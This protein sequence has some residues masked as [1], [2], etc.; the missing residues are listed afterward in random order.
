MDNH[1]PMHSIKVYISALL[2]AG[3]CMVAF[4][5][6]EGQVPTE[7]QGTV[8]DA[9]TLLP[10]NGISVSVPEFSSAITDSLGQFTIQVPHDESALIIFGLGYQSREVPLKGRREVSVLLNEQGFHSQDELAQLYYVTKPM[11]YTTQSVVT[12]DVSGDT[13]KRPGSSAEKVINKEVAGLGIMARSGIPGIGSNMFIRGFSS[14]YAGNQPLIILDGFIYETAQYGT[15]IIKG[16]LTNPLSSINTNDIENITVVRDA[17][18]IYGSRASNGVIYI[19][20]IHPSEMATKIDF[21]MYGGINYAPEQLPLL[22][23]EDYRAYLAEILQTSGI[24]ADSLRSMPFMIDDPAYSQYYGYHNQTN[25]QDE[26]F[27]NSTSQNVNLKITGGDD[28]ALYALSVGYQKH[29]GI[30]RET[31]YSRYSFRFNSHIRISSKLLLKTNLGF[32][33]NQHMLKEDGDAPHTNPLHTS[34]IKAPFL[35][36]NVLSSTGAVSPNLADSDLFGV[37]NPAAI[38]QS[39]SASSNNYKILGSVDVGYLFSDH[40]RADNYLGI[41][42]DKTRDNIFVPYLGIAADTLEEGIAGN[43]VAHK[44]DRYF[45]IYNDFRLNY[46]RTLAWKHHINALAGARISVNK[47]Q[48]DWGMDYNTPND[49]IRSLGSGVSSM[50]EVDGYFG[51]WNWVTYYAQAEYDYSHK[52]LV[53][54]NLALDGS[55]RFGGEADGLSLFG[56]KF[57]VFPSIAAAWI[58]SSEPFMANAAPLDFLKLRIS[59]GI[60]GND[61]IGNHTSSKYYISQNLL[62]SEGLVKGNLYNPGLQW[63]TNKKLNGGIDLAVF[64]ERFSLSA[65]LYQNRSMNLINVIDASPLSGFE[66][67]IDN[68][69]SFTCSGLDL[70]LNGRIISGSVKWDAGIILSR[71]RTE[72]VEFPEDKRITALYGANILSQVGQPVNQFYGYRTLGV[73]ATQAEADASGL[74]ALMPNTELIP[75]SAGDVHFEDLNGDQVIDENDMEVIG[76]PNPDLT[77]MLTSSVS[78]RGISLDAGVSFSYGNDIY[79]HV[80]YQLESM[81]NADNQT[82]VVL[83][84]WRGEGQETAVPK[85]SWGDPIGNSRF[86]DLW[87]EDGSYLRLSYVTLSY[88]IPVKPR[89]V[90]NLELFISGYNLFTMTSYLGMDPDFSLSGATLAQGID[91]GLT[92][93][94]RSLFMGI[95]IGL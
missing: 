71:Y 32:T 62:G 27:T 31:D 47:A 58:V 25:W 48:G 26:V 82:P 75:F 19:R 87:I 90:Q 67:Y 42:F 79:N 30:I 53:T 15:P 8:R 23:S 39:M 61:D 55:S 78:W 56:G 73:F 66:S 7:V 88:S 45:N 92:P 18:S 21:S 91:I 57:G 64:N 34:L 37:S 28:I 86:S 3:I 17:S 95:K 94:P 60:T 49:Q 80:R 84:R 50:R 4:P 89:F 36:P 11:A 10:V 68:N 16:F 24:T 54:L 35:Y 46:V 51:D 43:R 38:I 81:Q 85:A 83:N 14:I 65:D 6:A 2:L 59:Y 77:G 5:Q 40:F 63:E 29:E 76:D 69:G 13:W 9:S 12:V 1:K 74:R 20:T 72:L 70:G 22:K 93:Q 33:F 52:Y 44:V 41:N